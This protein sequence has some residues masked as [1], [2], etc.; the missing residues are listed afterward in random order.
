MKIY[1]IGQQ[2]PMQIREHIAMHTNIN[3]AG[4]KIIQVE[5]FP[6]NTAGKV[7]YAEFREP[8]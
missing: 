7:L 5:N 6:R 2:N 1:F 3:I 8:S 4:V